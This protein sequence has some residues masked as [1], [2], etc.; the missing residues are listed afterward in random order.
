[1]LLQLAEQLRN[2]AEILEWARNHAHWRQLPTP[3]REWLRTATDT[4]RQ[5]ADGLDEVGPAFTAPQCP[6]A[7]LPPPPAPASPHTA[8]ARR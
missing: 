1:M 7:V 5:L 2:A 4:T 8:P 3:A 6:P